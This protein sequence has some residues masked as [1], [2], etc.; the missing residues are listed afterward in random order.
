MSSGV[1]ISATTARYTSTK[2]AK[3]RNSKN[4]L[5]CSR[6]LG[7]VPGCRAASSLTMRADADPTWWT[8]SSALGRPRMNCS[9][10]GANGPDA[11]EVMRSLNSLD[12]VVRHILDG[13]SVGELLAVEQDRGRRVDAQL[14]GRLRGVGDLLGPFPVLH[15]LL[16]LVGVRAGLGGELEQIVLGRER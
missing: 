9:R 16:E 4:L 7:T 2:W 10:C 14:Q 15:G 8:W 13:P 11:A 1:R 5:S 12:E 3:S 6:S